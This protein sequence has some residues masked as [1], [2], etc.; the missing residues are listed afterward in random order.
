MKKPFAFIFGIIFIL[1]VLFIGLV[2]ASQICE[3]YDDFS[4]STLDMSKWE[5]SNDAGF[6]DEHFVNSNEESYHIAQYSIRHSDTQLIPKKEF[7]FLRIH[8]F[9]Q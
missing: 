5:E 8:T 2:S 7:Y 9:F 3:T 6:I 1:P 4:S